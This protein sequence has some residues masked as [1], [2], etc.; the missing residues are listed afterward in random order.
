MTVIDLLPQ[1]QA[2]RRRRT[3]ER[4][5]RPNNALRDI[6][7]QLTAAA[8]EL[9]AALQTA[10]AA[11]G[12]DQLELATIRAVLAWEDFQERAAEVPELVERYGWPIGVIL[13]DMNR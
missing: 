13:H 11:Q 1:I 6:C 8:A 4:L 9:N 12:T 3:T 2:A 5:Q 10:A 7:T